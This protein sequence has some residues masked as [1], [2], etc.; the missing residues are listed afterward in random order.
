MLRIPDSS[1]KFLE[2]EG[3]KFSGKYD[4]QT[5]EIMEYPLIAKA[6]SFNFKINKFHTEARGSIHKFAHE[7]FNIKDLTFNQLNNALNQFK[8][9]FKIDP[10]KAT[11]HNIEIGVNIIPPF[12]PT[13]NNLK[14]Y[15]VNYQNRTFT[16]MESKNGKIIGIH[17][18][19]KN[20]EIKIY[21]KTL[22]ENL[23]YPLIRIEVKYKRMQQLFKKQT[24]T[25]DIYFTELL[26]IKLFKLLKEDFFLVIHACMVLE[27]FDT[28]LKPKDELFIAHVSNPNYWLDISDK[29]R[30]KMKSKYL[31]L[32]KSNSTS[33]YKDQ[34]IRAINNKLNGFENSFPQKRE[35]L[36][37]RIKGQI[38]PFKNVLGEVLINQPISN[39]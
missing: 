14:K 12:E 13:L 19:L 16:E 18:E 22:Q 9:R 26:D 28:N 10:N 7:G 6:N 34:I 24:K 15:F 39:A 1:K 25:R 21:S 8:D 33:K 30:Y 2:I 5:F 27:D 37:T 32:V 23:P 35:I 11:I 17:F 3:L 20:Y 4:P 38:I 36:P 29:K 31:N